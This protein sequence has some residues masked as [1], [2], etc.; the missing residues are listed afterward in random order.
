ADKK[1]KEALP[2]TGEEEKYNDTLF[3]VLFAGLGS[4]LLF[5][6]S[7]RKKETK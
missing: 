5:A 2:E 6:K 4:L 3:G 1:A 7:R